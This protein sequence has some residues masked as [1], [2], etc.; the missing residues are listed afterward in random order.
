[1]TEE[2]IDELRQRLRSLGYLD[3]GVARFVLAPARGGRGPLALAASASIRVGLLGGALLGPSAALGLGARLPGLV[4]GVR[5]ALVLALYLSI[6]F[7]AA[8]SVAAFLISAGA[9]AV[10]RVRDEWCISRASFCE[11]MARAGVTCPPPE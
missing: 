2:P 11:L 7:F 6:L 1:M 9:A 8:V 5:D 10:V 4:S 3:E